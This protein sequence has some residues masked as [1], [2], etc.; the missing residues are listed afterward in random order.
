MPTT[1][2]MGSDV[3]IPVHVDHGQFIA[4]DPDAELDIDS[5]GESASREGLALWGGNGG[6]AVFTASHWTYTKLTV[7]LVP[8]R[9]SLA[10]HEYQRRA[11]LRRVRRTGAT[12]A[13]VCS[14]LPD[15]RR[16][17]TR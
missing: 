13:T 5:Y 6:I 1:L 8:E 14:L 7:R 17:P 3:T 2:T 15:R 10:E 9:P 4:C 11:P 12:R 16:V